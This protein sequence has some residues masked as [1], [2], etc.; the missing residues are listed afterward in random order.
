[1]SRIKLILPDIDTRRPAPRG[2]ILTLMFQAC[3][4]NER[5]LKIPMVF[6]DKL[7]VDV[8]VSRKHLMKSIPSAR[9]AAGTG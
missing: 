4:D 9:L 3:E 2:G 5:R 7:L 6:M 8:E 1:M